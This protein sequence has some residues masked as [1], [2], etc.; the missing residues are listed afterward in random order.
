MKIYF[1]GSIRGGREDS[2]LYKEYIEF[3]KS[4]NNEVLT[5]HVGNEKLLSNEKSITEVD[6]YERDIKWLNESDCVV[7]EVTKTSL[8]VG[9]ELGYAVMKN[10]PILSLY[11]IEDDEKLIGEELES[12]KKNLSAMISGCKKIKTVYYKK[13]DEAKKEIEIFLSFVEKKN[14]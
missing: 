11:R 8:G 13:I 3:M 5:E 10:K 6:I 14:N 1:C 9:F 2:K 12:K 4:K 7:S